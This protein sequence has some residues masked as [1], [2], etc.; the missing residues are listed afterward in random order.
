MTDEKKEDIPEEENKKPFIELAKENKLTKFKNEED[1]IKA[2]K[3]LEKAYSTRQPSKGDSDEEVLS[4]FA[5]YFKN[6][7]TGDTSLDGDLGKL[8]KSLSDESKIPSKLSDQLVSKA[9][10]QIASFITAKNRASVTRILSDEKTL[11]NIEKALG[12]E[13][14]IADFQRRYNDGVVVAQEARLLA[15]LGKEGTDA[16]DGVDRE[17]EEESAGNPETRLMAIL[18]DT[19]HPY[20][21]ES[22]PLHKDAVKEVNRLKKT[23]KI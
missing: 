2:Y 21:N 16:P 19:T 18:R 11:R 7:P 1:L 13:E 10:G 17:Q 22:S 15:K 8:S 12:D 3:D 14:S 9:A 6:S 23:L 4:K 5:N 20:V